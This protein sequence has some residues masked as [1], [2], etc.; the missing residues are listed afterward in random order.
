[1]APVDLVAPQLAGG[2][3]R[4][5]DVVELEP[6]AGQRAPLE[7]GVVDDL[8][9]RRRARHPLQRGEIAQQHGVDHP[10]LGQRADLHEADRVI[11]ERGLDVQPHER[12]L[13]EPMRELL[14]LHGP[15][16]EVDRVERHGLLQ[17]RHP[18]PPWRNVR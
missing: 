16:D 17:P 5:E 3:Q 1:V 2:G 4:V 7:A 12:V 6:V 15:G 11:A 14:E 9:H 8:H 13:G 18:G 10:G